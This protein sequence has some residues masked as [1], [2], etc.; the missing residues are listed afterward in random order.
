MILTVGL[1]V[2][3]APESGVDWPVVSAATLLSVAPLMLTFPSILAPVPAVVHA[4][5]HP[6][7]GPSPRPSSN[8]LGP[9]TRRS[10]PSGRVRHSAQTGDMSMCRLPVRST[11]LALAALG[12]AA[13]AAAGE[14]TLSRL[15]PNPYGVVEELYGL[16]GPVLDGAP[17][18][19]TA[20]EGLAFPA[21]ALGEG[22][23]RDLRILHFND[24]HNYLTKPHGKKGD[25]HVFAQMVRI[26]AETRAAAEADDIVL[27]LSAGD[28]HTGGVFDE[29]TG[30][31]PVDFVVD[32]AYTA[33]TV[34]GVDA[35]VLGNHEFDRGT[36]M[37][38][39][40]IESA[41][42][43]PVLSANTVGSPH[44][45]NGTHYFPAMI[46]VAKDLRIG[47]LGLTT[48]EAAWQWSPSRPR[49]VHHHV[50]REGIVTK[51]SPSCR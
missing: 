9:V 34:A 14:L 51:H 42:L 3:E 19:L 28:D 5:G 41:P 16:S 33:Y 48:A 49:R 38:A 29:L 43:L 50:P 12:A 13:P 10:W 46:A 20:A 27:F 35:T 31:N 37:L 45:D 15:I 40:W 24:L 32:P 7:R 1:G 6:L 25:T 17:V 44:V 26:A 47:I 8:F 30:F 11:I 18:T 36:A 39:T 21:A 23:A 22:E 2:F 4:R